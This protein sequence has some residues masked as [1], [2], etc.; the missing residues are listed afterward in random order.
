MRTAIKNLY[1]TP[2]LKVYYDINKTKNKIIN[3]NKFIDHNLS[4]KNKKHLHKFNSYK[5]MYQGLVKK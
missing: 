3:I 5:H 4:K 2:F 1:C